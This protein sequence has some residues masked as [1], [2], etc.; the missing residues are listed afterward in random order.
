MGNSNPNFSLDID[1]AKQELDNYYKQPFPKD[2]FFR[3]PPPADNKTFELGL[4]F[5]GSVSAGA[6][7]AGV[8]DFLLEALDA[9]EKA[10]TDAP[11]T[12][13]DHKVRLCAMS[14]AS[15]GGMTALILGAAMNRAIVPARSGNSPSFS[16]NPLYGTWVKGIDICNFLTTD[17]LQAEDAKVQTLLNSRRITELGHEALAASNSPKIRPYLADVVHIAVTI[18]NLKGVPYQFY[19]NGGTPDGYTAIKHED[20]VRFAIRHGGN[21]YTFLPPLPNE[22]LIDL[23]LRPASAGNANGWPKEWMLMAQA[24]MATGA[25]PIGLLPRD[26]VRPWNCCDPLILPMEKGKTGKVAILHSTLSTPPGGLD[27][28]L[29]VDGGTFNNEPF[30]LARTYLAGLLVLLC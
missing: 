10:K 19:L 24:A 18:A 4:C 15:G 29:C 11:L 12:V 7:I 3:D 17:D 23:A 2:F 13:P 20:V 25:F 30:E 8:A 21:A 27:S 9:W 22:S 16:E 6:Y 28:S 14:G 1:T 5:A 26:V